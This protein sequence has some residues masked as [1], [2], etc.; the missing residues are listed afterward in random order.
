[1]SGKPNSHS[2]PHDHSY[3]LLFSEPDMVADLLWGYVQEPWVKGLDFSTLGPQLRYL[4]VDE[5][6]Y[7]D[8]PLP[9]VRNLVS[10]LFGLENSQQPEDVQRVLEALAHW[11]RLPEQASLHEAF[12]VW[13]KQVFLPARIP[14][15]EFEQMQ[16][17]QEVNSMLAERVKEWPKEWE[18]KGLQ[19]GMQK[20]E[21]AVLRRLLTRRFGPLPDAIEQ[22]LQQASIEELEHWADNILDVSTLDEVFI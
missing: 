22:R 17:H 13:L 15:V 14:G 11:L 4:L 18:R 2:S 7:R 6:R 1:M 16:E 19:K 12:M 20:G 8:D 5:S 21:A 10:A 3:R 9:Q